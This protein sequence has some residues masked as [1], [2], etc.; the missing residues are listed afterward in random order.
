MLGGDKQVVEK[1]INTYNKKPT[2]PTGFNEVKP[3]VPTG[4]TEKKKM[5]K[6]KVMACDVALS[7]YGDL[8][9]PEFRA[10]YCQAWYELGRNRFHELASQ[11]RADG[12]YPQKL[13]SH[14][15]KKELT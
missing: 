4:T 11:A 13:F 3:T 15:L 1:I 12:T 8:I 6:E 9:N 5:S 14:L 7:E 2:V 10:W